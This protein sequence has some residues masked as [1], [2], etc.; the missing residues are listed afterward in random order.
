MAGVSAVANISLEGSFSGSNAGLS[1][2][3]TLSTL[4]IKL[5]LKDEQDAP[6]DRS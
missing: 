2:I 5:Y 6:F 1:L 3:K 4:V